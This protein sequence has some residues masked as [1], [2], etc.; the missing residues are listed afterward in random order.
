[1]VSSATVEVQTVAVAEWT[2][3]NSDNF[4]YTF[5][6]KLTTPTKGLILMPGANVDPRAYAPAAHRIA[7]AGFLVTLLP[8]PGGIAILG[9]HLRADRI[10]QDYPGI[11][12]W[13]VGGHSVAGTAACAFGKI[14][15]RMD[16][17]VVWASYPSEQYRID[18][19]NMKV[20]VIYGTNNPNCNDD[21]IDANR[22]YWPADTTYVRIEGA[23]HTQFG[24]YDTS[25]YPVQPNDDNATIT[26]QEQQDIIVQQTID[27]M[28]SLPVRIPPALETIT[29]ID[30]SG[31]ELVGTDGFDSDNNTSVVAMA[32][33]Q[34]MLFAMTRNDTF[35]A[36]IWRTR[37]GTCWEQV[38]FPNRETNGI[39]GNTS[40]N[41]VWG[42]MIVFQDRLYVGFS[43][44][45]Q[46]SV[47]GS[48]GAEIW[49]YN[50]TI[51]DDGTG[52]RWEPVISDKKDTE[53]VVMIPSGPGEFSPVSVN[54]SGTIFAISGCEDADGD[55]TALIT[56][57]ESNW[58]ENCF[59]GGTLTVMVGAVAEETSETV[60]APSTPE[61]S[62]DTSAT[63]GYRKFR[64]VGNTSDTLIIQQN[65][66][67]G[68]GRDADNESEFT[69]CA[70][71][72]YHNTFP[73]YSYKV[74]AVEVGQQYEIGMGTDENGFGDFWN[75]TITA[76]EIIDGRLYVA[77]GLNY[78][79]GAQVWYTDDGET[80]NVTLPANTFG[81]FHPATEYP[82]GQK[83]VATSITSIVQSIV[84]G[85]PL[86]Y[87]GSTGSSGALGACA[88]MAKLTASGWELIVDAGVD[89]NDN[90]TNE[91]G[92]GDGMSCTMNDGNFM[93]WN[94]SSYNDLL[95]AG[96]NS[97]GG[98]RV[99][100]S[101]DGSAEDGAWFYSVGDTPE[102]T[103]PLGFNGELNDPLT[104]YFGEDIYQNYGPNLYTYEDTL[105]AGMITVFVPEFGATADYLTGSHIWGSTNG[106]DWQ[107][108]TT[109]GFGDTEIVSFE[110]FSSYGQ[111]LYVAGSKAGEL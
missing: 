91:N 38:P 103:R 84:S 28:T 27:F 7:S 69:L 109:D 57:N 85:E 30:G 24:Y 2:T 77:T 8:V 23:N 94:L 71:Q 51:D 66:I 16:G 60:E 37:T 5:E 17:V 59:A 34:D 41:N 19:Q 96:I 63:G 81:L 45:L 79:Y 3:E 98:A 108:I 100:Y 80:W 87:A 83:P 31:W 107:P 105:Y 67:A 46:G 29:A 58:P 76:M 14:R 54:G 44:G 61:E 22:P 97:L 64:I 104:G 70:E 21:E 106:I 102:A 75:K 50:G 82:N 9:G 36:E 110:A 39:Y 65:E 11:E 90:G 52:N 12:Q 74:G 88:R 111:Y 55:T 89:A 35:G 99:I 1:M 25:P 15:C 73:L 33:Y 10:L 68:T 48:T 43:S 62:S 49:R 72:E 47:L 13:A 93:A 32:E 56:D 4:Y 53:T 101:L 26:R 40:I 20:I 92:F 78:E 86:I 95:V 42:R 6:P 18:D